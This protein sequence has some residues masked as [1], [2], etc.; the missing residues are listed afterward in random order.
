[1]EHC[2]TCNTEIESNTHLPWGRDEEECVDCMWDRV[3][4][5]INDQ[6]KY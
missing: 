3:K 1:M 2:K 5:F 4:P 6:I